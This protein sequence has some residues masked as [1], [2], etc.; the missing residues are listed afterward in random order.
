MAEKDKE[1]ERAREEKEKA[2]L[3]DT[4]LRLLS[5][6]KLVVKFGRC[7]SRRSICNDLH[8]AR[9]PLIQSTSTS[10]LIDML[11]TISYPSDVLT[12]L[13]ILSY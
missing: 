4:L 2:E 10:Y 7:V 12:I 6:L 5:P 8:C 3:H 1:K 13:C 9:L 11:T